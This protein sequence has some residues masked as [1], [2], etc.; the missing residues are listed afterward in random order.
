MNRDIR[1]VV[2]RTLQAPKVQF[3]YLEDTGNGRK[4]IQRQNHKTP[5]EYH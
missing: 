2:L 1:I 5:L 4:G 3:P